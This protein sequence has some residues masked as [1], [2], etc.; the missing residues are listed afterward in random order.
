MGA[1]SKGKDRCCGLRKGRERVRKRRLL[2][3][4]EGDQ[5]ALSPVLNGSKERPRYSIALD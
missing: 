2:K 3:G 5:A 1:I 4:E